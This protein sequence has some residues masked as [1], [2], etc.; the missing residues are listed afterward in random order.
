[1]RPQLTVIIFFMT[2]CYTVTM[3]SFE[4][5]FDFPVYL[6]PPLTYLTFFNARKDETQKKCHLNPAYQWTPSSVIT[7]PMVLSNDTTRY[8]WIYPPF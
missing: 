8:R 6:M 7:Q 3:T 2:L 1:M 5:S 4:S